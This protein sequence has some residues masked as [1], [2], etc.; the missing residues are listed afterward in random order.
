MMIRPAEAAG[1]A[2]RRAAAFL[3]SD[4]MVKRG[5]SRKKLIA[6][7]RQRLVAEGF[8]RLQISL[9]LLLTAA[10]GFFISFILLQIGIDSMAFRYPVA[11][12]AAYCVFL[13]LLRVWLWL[14]K[15][16]RG[17]LD[18]DLLPDVDLDIIPI[19]SGG[20]GGTA[21]A[22]IDPACDTGG[23]FAGAGAGGSWDG[24]N[25][26]GYASPTEDGGINAADA[27]DTTV[28]ATGDGVGS[29]LDGIDL[30]EGLWI[31]LV[32][33][34]LTG[35]LLAA[36]YVVYI[37]PVLLAEVLVDGV[38]VT[39]L[40]RRVK[41]ADQRHWLRTA[42]RKT[43]LPAIIVAVCFAVA[44]YAMEQIAPEARSVGEVWRYAQSD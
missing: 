14:Q 21:D 5:K 15:N 17:R 20:S 13:L 6:L 10:A 30:D 19:P 16:D 18:G 37:A 22:G 3:F 2:V 32:I 34:V 23:D 31:A 25:L 33:V 29:L 12:A 4:K 1:A 43:L 40:Y 44:G 42:V 35:A 38:L 27:V 28:E 26:S 9:I 11:I 24:L 41:K 7:V 39:G 36:L 8:P